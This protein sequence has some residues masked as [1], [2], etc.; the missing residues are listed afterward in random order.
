MV[1]GSDWGFSMSGGGFQPKLRVRK[2]GVVFTVVLLK[3]RISAIG[4]A[5]TRFLIYEDCEYGI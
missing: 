5:I 3:C 2:L 1:G 4:L